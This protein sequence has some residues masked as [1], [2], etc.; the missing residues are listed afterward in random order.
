MP[1]YVTTPNIRPTPA[2]SAMA[3]APQNVTLIAPT[4]IGAPPARAAIP[5]RKVR[6]S[7]EDTAT[8]RM[9]K[10]TGTTHATTK[11]SAAP[12]VKVPAEENAA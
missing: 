9:S 10:L 12:I 1:H 3:S 8:R 7:R 6:K 4:V 2:V 11:G 5:P